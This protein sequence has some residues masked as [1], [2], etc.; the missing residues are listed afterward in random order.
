VR[1]GWQERYATRTVSAKEAVRGVRPGQRVFV[2]SGCAEPVALVTALTERADLVDIE[3][4]HIMTVGGAPYADATQRGRFRHNAFF[5]GSN[6]RAAIAAGDADY[7]PIFLS[8]VPGLFRSGRLPL[9][10]AL[11]TVTPPDKHGFC[12]LGISV[13][14]VKAAVE[15]A[16]VVVAEVNPAM[17]RTHGASFLH[18]DDIDF[19]VPVTAPVLELAAAEPDETSRR[20]GQFCA[21]LVDHGATLQ[22]GIG[23]IPNAILENLAAK[24]DL[25]L[26][27]EM[28]SDGVMG[29]IRAGV[30]TCAR[31]TFHPGKAVTTFCMG[32]RALYDFVD[33][34]PFFEFLPTEVV[35][36]PVLIARN[37][38]MVSINSALQIDLTGQ[39]CADSIGT[40]FYSGIGGQVDF[41]RGAARSRG[42]RSIIALPSTAQGGTVSRIVPVL[43]E[44]AGVVTTRGDVFTVVTEHGVAEL[45]GRTVR[46]RALALIG[47]AHPDFRDEL[48]AAA[49]A[50]RIVAL[51]QI[52]WPAR[53][54]PYPVELETVERFGGLEVR[55]RPLRPA[56]ERRLR[57]FFYSHSAETVYQ[58]YHVALR[59]LPPQR[60]QQLCM[61]D[62]EAELALAGF[63]AEGE[64]E[65]MVAV[66]RW[67]LERASGLA[68]VA[69]VVHDDLQGRGIGTYLLRRL[70]AIARER[71]IHG[72]VAYVLRANARM[73]AAFHKCGVPVKS[74]SEGNLYTLVMRFDAE[75][76]PPEG[77]GQ[78][79]RGGPAPGSP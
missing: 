63:V 76:R 75:S 33:D 41:I 19:L 46:E 5:I 78:R 57:D 53:G 11:V 29:L 79:R 17:P 23:Q 18:V 55:F 12:S 22:L 35:N 69:F 72:F 70:I 32:S 39:V 59:A 64:A 43:A 30:V 74:T 73:L 48:L 47:I 20:I 61:L 49:K 56:D 9:D 16:R 6:V 4:V 21:G 13:D 27:T 34:N 66:G 15:V 14:V 62:Y 28:L 1:T 37:D 38:R 51:D 44:G 67:S 58:R 45:R 60:I 77:G 68:E 2:G 25:G 54:R 40:R 31:K 65:R 7:T 26:H 24:Q 52:P 50:R 8:E 10:V 36:D 3:V 42:G 71:G